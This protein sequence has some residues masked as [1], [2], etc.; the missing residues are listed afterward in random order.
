[1]GDTPDLSVKRALSRAGVVGGA[2][3]VAGIVLFV[4]LWVVLSDMAQFPRLIVSLCVPPAIMAALVGGYILF[5]PKRPQ[6][7]EEE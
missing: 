5:G 1:M 3:A 6:Q 4:I 7:P 2:L